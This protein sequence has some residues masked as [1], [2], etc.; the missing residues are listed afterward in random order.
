MLPDFREEKRL[1]KSGFRYLVGIDEVGRG[2]LAG[3]V[4]ACAVLVRRP[5]VFLD[6]PVLKTLAITDSK[7]LAPS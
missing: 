7:K 3:P 1:W 4:V 5:R 2:S 6:D